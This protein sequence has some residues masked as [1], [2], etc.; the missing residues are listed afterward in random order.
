MIGDPAHRPGGLT[1]LAGFSAASRDYLAVFAVGFPPASRDRL[2]VLALS[3]VV[4][5]ATAWNPSRGLA[6]SRSSSGRRH[7]GT[8]SGGADVIAWPLLLFVAFAAGWTFRFLYDFESVAEPS[9]I[10]RALHVLAAL[11]A[12]S[13]ALAIVSA[14]GSGRSCG[15][16][17]G[18]RST[19]TA[20]W[21][22]PRF[23]RLPVLRRARGRRGAVL[24]PAPGRRGAAGASPARRARRRR[25][26]RAVAVGERLA[27]SPARPRPFWQLTG[28]FSGAAIDPNALGIL[29]ASG[30]VLAVALAA[31][32]VARR[33][34][35]RS[36]WRSSRPAWP[37]PARG[38][39]SAWRRSAWRGFSSLAESRL[40]VASRRCDRCG[41]RGD[42]RRED[43][44]GRAGPREPAFSRSSTRACRR[45]SRL[46]AAGPL[47]ERVTLF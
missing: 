37:S 36:R 23:G 38:A 5:L 2:P 45:E 26:L 22:P 33:R 7:R 32:A 41:P 42:R 28:R 10:D 17:R 46:D 35:L 44:R 43:A 1:R 21:T 16:S 3:D 24:S 9:P 15:A 18:A 34:R 29:C 13:A 39:G 8:A 31:A 4:A 14:R 40:V 6:C 47:E 20:C 12:M 25:V 19:W 30:A 11:W 27:S